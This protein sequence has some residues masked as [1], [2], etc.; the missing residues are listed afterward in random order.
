LLL[1]F[2]D[3]CRLFGC[4]LA[5]AAA[6]ANGRGKGHSGGDGQRQDAK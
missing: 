3:N 5:S 1:P 2:G 4:E 6:G